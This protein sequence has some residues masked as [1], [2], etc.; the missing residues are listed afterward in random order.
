MS[1]RVY[2]PY[3]SW[4][5]RGNESSTEPIRIGRNEREISI[6]PQEL[7]HLYNNPNGERII[8]YHWCIYQ[9]D[10]MIVLSFLCPSI[11]LPLRRTSSS[12]FWAF[13]NTFKLRRKNTS[14][15]PSASIVSLQEVVLFNSPP[16]AKSV[17]VQEIS[18]TNVYEE[19]SVQKAL[20]V[21]DAVIQAIG[22]LFGCL[23]PQWPLRR[24]RTYSISNL[25]MA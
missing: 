14:L 11:R 13:N 24:R 25:L 12:W 5:N 3:L 18:K 6:Y 1:L 22:F 9:E 2:R 19:H 15:I 7:E 10:L 23:R 20:D 4:A 8:Q 17:E 21:D 16:Q